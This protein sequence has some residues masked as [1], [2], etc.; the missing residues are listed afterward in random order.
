MFFTFSSLLCETARQHNANRS[1]INNVNS[2]HKCQLSLTANSEV[3]YHDWRMFKGHFSREKLVINFVL[4]RVARMSLRT[5][6]FV[7]TNLTT[8]W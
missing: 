6:L 4:A 8:S 1:T 2:R 7:S 5:Y 3:L